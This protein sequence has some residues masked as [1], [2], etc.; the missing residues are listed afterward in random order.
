MLGGSRGA[1]WL[2]S[3]LQSMGTAWGD[4]WPPFNLPLY[5][6]LVPAG[7]ERALLSVALNDAT[8]ASV[9]PPWSAWYGFRPDK[10][11]LVLLLGCAPRGTTEARSRD[12]GKTSLTPEYIRWNCQSISLSGW[13]LTPEEVTCCVALR[14][15]WLFVSLLTLTFSLEEGVCK[16]SAKLFFCCL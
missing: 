9:A 7:A 6:C 14:A 13:G 16:N 2:C 8:G 1:L 10:T 12:T 4:L 3:P 5:G 11:G 15:F